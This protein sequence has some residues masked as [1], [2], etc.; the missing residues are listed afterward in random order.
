M[1]K[2]GSMQVADIAAPPPNVN[3]LPL[4]GHLVSPELG[5]CRS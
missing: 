2:W 4:D 5:G 3:C 1:Q